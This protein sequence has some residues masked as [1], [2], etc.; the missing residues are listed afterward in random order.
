MENVYTNVLSIKLMS[1]PTKINVKNIVDFATAEG[2]SKLRCN[3]HTMSF[4]HKKSVNGTELPK[5]SRK[6][7]EE[8][9]D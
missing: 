8:N 1:S 5:Y 2:E 9:I 3:N 7:K 6:L 4:R